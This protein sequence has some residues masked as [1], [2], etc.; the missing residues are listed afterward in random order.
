VLQLMNDPDAAPAGDY[1]FDPLGFGGVR[2]QL[3][4]SGHVW[5]C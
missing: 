4:H 1:K 2:K 3:C 5:W